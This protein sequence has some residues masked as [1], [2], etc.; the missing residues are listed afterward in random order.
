MNNDVVAA[1]AMAICVG[2]AKAETLS[3]FGT[4]FGARATFHCHLTETV[5][6]KTRTTL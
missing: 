1:Q 5:T 4:D 6:S 3:T 2:D